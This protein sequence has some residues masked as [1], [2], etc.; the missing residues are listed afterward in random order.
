MQLGDVIKIMN[1]RLQP[2]PGVASYSLGQAVLAPASPRFSA[3]SY[4]IKWCHL[5]RPR[6]SSAA[7]F[8]FF[9][10]DAA[11]AANP[12][13]AGVRNTNSLLFQLL[14]QDL[15]IITG[16]THSLP[17]YFY[18]RVLL[19]FRCRRVSLACAVGYRA[20]ASTSNASPTRITPL[21]RAIRF[22]PKSTSPLSSCAETLQ[23]A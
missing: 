3:R 2:A 21:F 6:F 7:D 14:Q 16:K 23:R 15:L 17:R 5:R 9:Q 4:S 22:W 20:R 12:S 10:P 11:A 19:R 8:S 18:R 1:D 13:P